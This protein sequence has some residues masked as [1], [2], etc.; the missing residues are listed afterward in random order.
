MLSG[1]V[2]LIAISSFIWTI[3]NTNIW[4]IQE[5]QN[6]VWNITLFFQFKTD[7]FYEE[8]IT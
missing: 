4:Y 7:I 2:V 6:L 3:H 5:D 1:V 8:L